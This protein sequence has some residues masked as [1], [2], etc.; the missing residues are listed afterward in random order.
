MSKEKTVGA[1]FCNRKKVA[2]ENLRVKVMSKE[3]NILFRFYLKEP[4]NHKI[5]YRKCMFAEYSI[6][7]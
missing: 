6:F 7:S 5:K 4:K 3:N 1:M 2:Q